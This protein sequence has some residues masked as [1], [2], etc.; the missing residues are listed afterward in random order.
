MCDKASLIT[1]IRNCCSSSNKEYENF[2]SLFTEKGKESEYFQNITYQFIKEYLEITFSACKIDAVA[3]ANRI[4]DLLT[5]RH[6]NPLSEKVFLGTGKPSAAKDVISVMTDICRVVGELIDLNRP[7]IDRCKTMDVPS[8]KPS[9]ICKT[10][11]VDIGKSFEDARAQLKAL[12][13]KLELDSSIRAFFSLR[14]E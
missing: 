11:E 5:A 14:M 1:V 6:F 13:R 4:K 3:M 7:I 2:E 12:Q 10:V 9:E 8:P